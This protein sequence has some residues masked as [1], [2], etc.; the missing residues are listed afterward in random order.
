MK[1]IVTLFLVL[2]FSISV[3]SC[4]LYDEAE[5]KAVGPNEEC[6]KLQDIYTNVQSAMNSGNGI[7]PPG[8]SQ[9]LLSWI[10]GR[11]EVIVSQASENIF[12]N[13]STG[14][15]QFAQVC[16][17]LAI[18]F[19]GAGIMMGVTDAKPY[20]IVM[21]VLKITIVYTLVTEW[22]VAKE[23]IFDPFNNLV[24]DMVQ[25]AGNVFSAGNCSGNTCDIF[26]LMDRM[27]AGLFNIKLFKVIL[28][29]S[30][31]GMSGIFYAITLLVM[32]ILYFIAAAAALK[33]YLIAMIMRYILFAMLPI[34]VM[35]AFFNQTKSL[36]D[37]WL[38]Q[39][40]NFTL[41]PIL[42]FVMVGLLHLVMFNFVNRIID[43]DM[44]NRY[45]IDSTGAQVGAEPCIKVKEASMLNAKVFKHWGIEYMNSNNKTVPA[46]GP[47]AQL[48][49]NIWMS[50]SVI[51]ICYLMQA[52]IPWIAELAGSISSG[53]LSLSQAKIQG[54]ERI[55]GY[56]KENIN[57][58]G[59]SLF[60]GG[61]ASRGGDG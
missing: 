35:F 13:I 34:F 28:A 22:D 42:V 15:T 38:N 7:N 19:F 10:A 3:S 45:Y 33:I 11:T 23:Y 20:S 61:G 41:Q 6:E 1:K 14:V 56:V 54:A 51:L 46:E 52:M 59:K 47:F 50:I 43:A 18:I 4:A 49:V 44:W 25:S 12:G 39:V 29:L 9:G 26:L 58:A 60:S 5:Q 53:A 8:V 40:I 24:R 37:G 36:F 21:L 27:L 57:K 17:I 30:T 31:T 2:I 32:I 16:V 48:P 55:G